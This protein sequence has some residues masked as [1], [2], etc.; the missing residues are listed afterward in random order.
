MKNEL[1]ARIS[2]RGLM[3]PLSSIS[4]GELAIHHYHPSS[5]PMTSLVAIKKMI[6]L[7]RHTHR[8]VTGYFI[9]THDYFFFSIWIL[10]PSMPTN[11]YYV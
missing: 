9:Q 3:T 8:M 11:H 2:G 10:Y 1:G 5:N 7:F 4:I 6:F